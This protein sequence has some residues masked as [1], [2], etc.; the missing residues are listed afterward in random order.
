MPA[1]CTVTLDVPTLGPV[2]VALAEYG[3]GA[4]VLLLHGGG[5]PATVTPWAESLEGARVLVPVHPGFDGTE[6]PPGLDSVRGL[7]AVYAALLDAVDLRDVLVVGNSLG[8]WVAAELAALGSPRVAGVV[9]VDAVGLDVPGHPV[10]D[11]FTLTPHQVAELS[12]FDPTGRVL[13]PAA[14]PPPARERLAANRASLGIYGGDTMTDPTLAARLATVTV[15]VRVVWGEA[16]RIADVE[17]GRAF[18]RAVPGGSFTLLERAGHLPQLEAPAAL[19][20]VVR[21]FASAL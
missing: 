4:P 20:A 2:E 12:W 1:E 14:M 17:V 16:D 11:F 10:V 8:G 21:E 15:P 5:G 3:A 7:A 6:R 9:L 13:D 19:T 18:A